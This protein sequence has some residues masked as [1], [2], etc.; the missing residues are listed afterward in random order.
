MHTCV[1]VCVCVCM[2]VCA[3]A[4]VCCAH[5]LVSVLLTYE[6]GG[7]VMCVSNYCKKKK[8]KKKKIQ[9]EFVHCVCRT[10]HIL[11][12]DLYSLPVHV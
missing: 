11:Q 2:S 3:C 9:C 1:C 5:V 12:I 10:V 7:D 6:W 8:K 4:F